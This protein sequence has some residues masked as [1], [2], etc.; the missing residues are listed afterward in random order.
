ME[1]RHTWYN[2]DYETVVG[3]SKIYI[4]KGPPHHEQIVKQIHKVATI[5]IS[6]E[7]LLWAFGI[8][9]S[10]SF[11]TPVTTGYDVSLLP[12]ADLANHNPAWHHMDFEEEND[13]NWGYFTLKRD[14]QARN[15]IFVR[16]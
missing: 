10:R 14:V 3:S 5:D 15:E 4:Y 2:S 13:T 1:C 6:F 9:L 8:V 16:F 7:E 11:P 12:I